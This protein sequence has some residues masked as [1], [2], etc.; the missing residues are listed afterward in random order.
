M[1]ILLFLFLLSFE[2]E[3]EKIKKGYFLIDVCFYFG[4]RK[5]SEEYSGEK[6]SG[7]MY[8]TRAVLKISGKPLEFLEISGMVGVGNISFDVYDMTY[9]YITDF[10][11]S[12]ELVYGGGLTLNFL[13]PKPP[14]Y[15][16]AFI[17]GSF[18]RLVSRDRVK[19]MDIGW[20]KEII[21]WQELE[22]KLGLE[23]P[24]RLWHLKG[25]IKGSELFGTDTL[26]GN[27]K[28]EYKMRASNKIGI[29]FTFDI[30]LEKSQKTAFYV[31]LSAVDSN[32]FKLGIKRWL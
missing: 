9:D 28:G 7:S 1:K 26:E 31:D 32:Y 25:G 18:L 16:G 21:D 24:F 10:D 30:F 17:E 5:V 3:V 11:G 6:I 13:V 2:N 8:S 20:I 4:E 19:I 12:Y 15:V 27:G 22:I 23:R 14:S 29:F